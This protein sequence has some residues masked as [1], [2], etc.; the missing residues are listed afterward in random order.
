MAERTVI[1]P[2]AEMDDAEVYGGQPALASIP[3]RLALNLQHLLCWGAVLV[4]GAQHIDDGS[5]DETDRATFFR[6]RMRDTC[7]NSRAIGFFA[8]VLPKTTSASPNPNPT[9]TGDG[10]S[11]VFPYFEP[12][13][14]ATWPTELTERAVRKAMTPTLGDRELVFGTSNGARVAAVTC[15]QHLAVD[16]PA[17]A[18]LDDATYKLLDPTIY[19]T[20]K[21]INAQDLARLVDLYQNDSD[22]LFTTFRRQ[23]FCWSVRG[24]GS[25][26][27]I[28]RTTATFANMLDQGITSRTATSPGWTCPVQY[29][30]RF[31]TTK[32][33]CDVEVYAANTGGATSATVRFASSLGNADV[34][35]NSATAQWWQVAQT[36]TLDTTIEADRVDVL[37]AGDGTNPLR[38]WAVRCQERPL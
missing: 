22:A 30:G 27:A 1:W 32:I 25:A 13:G 10:T 8:A 17:G 24:S 3:Q 9:I 16:K 2:F 14:T 31:G 21:P 33:E 23:H 38:V 6:W 37:M 34:I 35:V 11:V 26:D 28:S 20:S 4:V 12:G 15:V 5:I 7:P 36:L 19:Q 18:V 29:A